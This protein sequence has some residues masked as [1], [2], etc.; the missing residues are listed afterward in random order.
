MDALMRYLVIETTCIGSALILVVVLGF[1]GIAMLGLEMRR[2]PR[3]EEYD[4]G[5][6]VAERLAP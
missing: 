6:A 1:L 4:G 2:A 3:M 5:D